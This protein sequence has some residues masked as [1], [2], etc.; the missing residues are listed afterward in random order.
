MATVTTK[1]MTADEFFLLP[2]PRNGVRQE[3]VKGEVIEMPP[4]G[5]EHG[6]VMLNL[7]YLVKHFLK[8]HPI[9]T[10][11][12]ETGV[13]TERNEEDT[14]R[15]PDLSYYSNERFPLGK[16]VVKYHD[17]PPDLCVEILSPSNTRKE[18]REKIE[19]YFEVGVR[20]VWV[21]DPEDR[22]ALV[23]TE[24][25][26]GQTLY[27]SAELSGG[28]VLPGFTCKVAELFE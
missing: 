22:S 8:Q 6:R 25:D 3:L 17:L 27:G 28:E 13:Q 15:G 26:K 11:V 10:A 12:A 9:G 19:E 16:R 4:P 23:L 7:G 14:V 21:V 2:K 5:F 18:L 24:P 1:P 20:M